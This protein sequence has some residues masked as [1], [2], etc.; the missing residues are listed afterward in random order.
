[1]IVL[2][3][4]RSGTTHLVNLIAADRRLR[5]MPLWEGQA[6][7]AEENPTRG[8]DDPRYLR[9]AE[10][11][12]RMHTASQVVVA[13]HPMEPD[14]LH[15]ELELML[16]D[17]SSYSIE[18]V[19]RVPKR[20]DYYQAHDQRPRYQYLKTALKI[21]Q[22]YRSQDRWVLNVLGT[23]NRSYPSSRPFRIRPSS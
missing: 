11:W 20:L 3:L 22:W 2:G 6:S 12:Q 16:P 4:P 9:A 23:S 7:V 19:A 15:E 10:N 8:E 5:S 18:W 13:M 14:H 21:L 17:F 1:M